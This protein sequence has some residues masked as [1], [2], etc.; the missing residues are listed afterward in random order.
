MKLEP[1]KVGWGSNHRSPEGL[2]SND[3]SKSKVTELNLDVQLKFNFYEPSSI[4]A[5][6]RKKK[7]QKTY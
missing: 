7:I 3:A 5:L 6:L 2:F 4:M 1:T